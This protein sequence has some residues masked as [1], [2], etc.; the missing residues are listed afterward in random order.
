MNDT[1][2]PPTILDGILAIAA[3]AEA[4]GAALIEAARALVAIT[5]HFT[6]PAPEASRAVH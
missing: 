2:N 4:N 3:G 6:A 5:T 1:P